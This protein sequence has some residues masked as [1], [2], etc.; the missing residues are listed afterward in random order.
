MSDRVSGILHSNTSTGT[1]KKKSEIFQAFISWNLDDYGLQI[2]K[3]PN[4]VS[5]Y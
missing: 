3:T 1:S 2:T 4:S 5:R